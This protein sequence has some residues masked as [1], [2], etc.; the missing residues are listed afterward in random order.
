MAH[1]KLSLAA[2]ALT[3]LF[4][5]PLTAVAAHAAGGDSDHDGI[6]NAYER[7]HGLNPHNPRDAKQDPDRD[8]LTNLGEYRH[9][10]NLRSADSDRDQLRD[11]AEVKTYD[12]DPTD[13]DTDDDQLKDGVEVKVEDTDP[14]NPDSDDDTLS[15]GD[16]VKV[17][18]TNPNDVDT[19]DDNLTDDVEVAGSTDPC[20]ADTDGD[21]VEDGEDA[22][23]LFGSI[24]SYNPDTG[25]LSVMDNGGNTVVGVV[26]NRTKI[27]FGG[28][29]E[30]G[31]GG[32]EDGRAHRSGG[33]DDAT[34][35]DLLAGTAVLQ[36]KFKDGS[37]NLAKV[38]IARPV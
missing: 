38:E 26:T 8:G 31:D 20:D 13:A 1:K 10:T 18:G 33:G 11:G 29:P 23:T 36:M 25:E 15:D 9:G 17:E 32:G 22:E 19:D 28:G 12:T 5:L 21:G 3:T 27:E 24:V 34:P 30:G 6:P 37:T 4:C 7:A 14:N 16:E 2:T 35:A